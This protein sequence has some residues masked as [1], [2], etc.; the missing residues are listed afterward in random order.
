MTKLR[1]GQRAIRERSNRAN[2][3]DNATQELLQKLTRDLGE[4]VKELNCLYAISTLAERQGVSLAEIIKGIVDLIPSAWRYPEITCARI[5]LEGQEFRTENF[6]E[7]A[8]KQASDINLHG[9]RVGTLEVCYLE[10]KPE[11]DEGPFSKEERN[12]IN[13][14]SERSG[15]IAERKQAEE[16]LR[17]SERELAIRNRISNIFLTVPDDEM[18]GEVLQVVLEAMESR[19][20]VFGYIDENRAL[21]CPSMTR[22]IWEKCQVP[23]K[24]IV[25]PRESW[26]GIWGRA[27]IEKRSLYANEGLRVPEGHVS[28]QRVLVVPIMYQGNTIGLLEVANKKTDYDEKDQRSLEAIVGHIAPVLHARLQRE[29]HERK[30]EEAE[31]QLR[32]QIRF[33]DSAIDALTDTF[34]VFSPENGKAQRWNKAFR[35]ISGY[36]DE[37]IRRLKAPD[38]YYGQEDL[39]KAAAATQA[40]FEEGIATVELSLI[41]KDGRHVPFEYSGV[42]IESPEGKPWVC[43]IGRDLS[44]RKQAEEALLRQRDNLVSIIEAMEDGVYMANLPHNIVYVNPA[45]RKEFGPVEGKKCYEYFHDRNGPCPWCK[46]DEVFA[47]KTVRW[48]WYF[49]KNQK[50]YDLIDAPVRNTDGS[51]SK[52]AIFRDV[53]ERKKLD[54][55][56]DE[57]IGLVSHELRSPLTVVIGAVSTVLTEGERL[58]TEETRQLLQDAASEAESLSNLVSNLLELSRA[59]AD[60]LALHLE[61]T[62]VK[63]VAQN[64]VERIRQQ[65]PSHQF[66][67]DL[68]RKLPQIHADELKLER[69]LHNLLENA[70]KYSPQGSEVRIFAKPEKERLLIG[71]G[72]Q[73]IG[74]SPQDQAKLFGPFQRLEDSRLNGVKGIGLG[75]LVCRRLVEAHGGRIWVESE[76][77]QGSTFFFRLPFGRTSTQPRFSR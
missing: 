1:K 3:V 35:D 48:E 73:G 76:P 34:F 5:L 12:L 45:L 42:Q 39:E 63:H 7:T 18:Y 31:E 8:W 28:I 77:G 2:A 16:A 53:T 44:E 40:V 32:L 13:A 72:D 55:L 67:I 58:S 41:S 69:I 59:Q 46:N 4:R 52:L 70:V 27:L 36:S 60:R 54:Q 14:I 9:E 74:I 64:A 21:V 22:D 56:K 33:I 66:V 20:G 25:F 26:G 19:F 68:P 51:V 38:S 17:K 10:D 65:F 71:V 47:G 29:T 6:R 15:R 50:T 62:N 23:D 24:T 43:A 30:R 75:L 61:P 11:M 57:F 37:E 49:S